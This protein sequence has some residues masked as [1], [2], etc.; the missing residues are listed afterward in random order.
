MAATHPPFHWSPTPFPSVV[1]RPGR[2][3]DHSFVS[4]TEVKNEWTYT[5]TEPYSFMGTQ[6]LQAYLV[7]KDKET[8]HVPE[9]DYMV[10]FEMCQHLNGL[11]A[12]RLFVD[13]QEEALQTYMRFCYRINSVELCWQAWSHQYSTQFRDARAEGPSFHDNCANCCPHYAGIRHRHVAAQLRPR[14]GKETR[15]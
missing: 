14:N 6:E 8:W 15:D 11:Q 3:V 10:S 12:W 1:K 7:S 4:R 5:C 9:V 13:W 2:E